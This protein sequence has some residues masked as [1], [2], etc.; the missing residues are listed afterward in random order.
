VQ[1]LLA[2]WRRK[3]PGSSRLARPGAWGSVECVVAGSWHCVQVEGT[4]EAA[5]PSDL[6]CLL[7]TRWKWPWSL[8]VLGHGLPRDTATVAG[9]GE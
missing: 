1:G 3:L 9:L 8:L 6:N 2:L 7:P 5:S 4:L